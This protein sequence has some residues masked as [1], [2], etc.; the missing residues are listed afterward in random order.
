[1][2][3]LPGSHDPPS[4]LAFDLEVTTDGQ[5]IHRIGAVRADTGERLTLA[6]RGVRTCLA[7]LDALAEDAS[8]V[9][10][11]NIIAFDLP[12]LAAA[13]PDLGLLRLP[14]VDT[15]RL[16]PLAFPANPY[17]RL[18]KYHQDDALRSGP[19]N[20]P[21]HDSGLALELFQDQREAPGKMPSDFLAA[22]HRLCTTCAGRRDRALDDLF[23]RIRQA[24]RATSEGSI[25]AVASRLDGAAC[26]AARREIL[27]PVDDHGW[28]LACALAWLHVAG[29]NSVV[30]PWVAISFRKRRTSSSA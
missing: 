18:V 29:G 26:I 21:E 17:H 9:L 12:I 16:S 7:R 6:G 14:V 1:M 10:C 8:F 19:R 2:N 4:C 5:R 27:E 15:L 23:A 30:P 3:A 20:S 28:E 24:A 13:K 11:H 25:A 22:W